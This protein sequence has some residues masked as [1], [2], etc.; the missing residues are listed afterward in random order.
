M[1]EHI[2]P[3]DIHTDRNHNNFLNRQRGSPLRSLGEI[4]GADSVG[5]EYCFA[6]SKGLGPARIYSPTLMGQRCQLV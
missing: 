3:A 6:R 5:L 2:T 1:N 4:S